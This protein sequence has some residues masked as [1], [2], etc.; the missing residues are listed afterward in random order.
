MTI[1][2][3]PLHATVAVAALLL[4]ACEACENK[5]SGG[6][7]TPAGS[8]S[9]AA[10]DAAPATSASSNAATPSAAIADKD[11]LAA[12][13]S[14]PIFRDDEDLT[15]DGVKETWRLE[16]TKPPVPN[17]MSADTA[18]NCPCAGFA[19]GEK[20][21]MDL[22]RVVPGKKDERMNLDPL[23]ADQ[24]T[25]L[26]RWAVTK[27]DV[28]RALAADGG[29]ALDL[30]GISMR[31]ITSVIKFADY[32]HDGRASEF[33]LQV[34][35]MPCGHTQTIVVGVSKSNPK[36][37][38]FAT[39]EKPTEPLTL[40]HASDWEKVRQKPSVDITQI[41]CGDHGATEAT[42]VH[43]K[44]DGDLHATTETKKCP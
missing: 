8:T 34:N 5:P 25:E 16:W 33:L 23:F 24:D 29:G 19:F 42:I 26:Q 12:L 37:H 44:A 43:V 36:L 41:A 3:S 10:Q 31:P 4:F 6:S 18:F 27:S 15:L 38:A 32:D 39:A 7:A 30:V 13:S 17:C 40:D 1:R 20:G 35:A 21:S 22:V 9:G 14:G 11:P 2:T 28:D